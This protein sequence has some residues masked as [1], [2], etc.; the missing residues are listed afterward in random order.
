MREKTVAWRGG[1]GGGGQWGRF[2][3]WKIF[4]LTYS[5]VGFFLPSIICHERLFLPGIPLQEFF[6]LEISLQDV[7]SE[8]THTLP[9]FKSQMV[10]PS[11]DRSQQ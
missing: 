7:F 4:F 2:G 11:F 6:P 10:A 3:L 1:G 5:G 8:I 9:H